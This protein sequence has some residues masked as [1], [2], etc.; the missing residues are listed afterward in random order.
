[1]QFP[2]LNFYFRFSSALRKIASVIGWPTCMDHV[3]AFG[4]HFAFARVCIEVGID[5]EFLVEIRMKYIEKT[6]LRRVEYA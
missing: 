3:T 6:I 2:N 1:M 4:T 5:A